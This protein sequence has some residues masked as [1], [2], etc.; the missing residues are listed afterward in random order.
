M[1]FQF[2]FAGMEIHFILTTRLPT[3]SVLN[4]FQIQVL[5][6]KNTYRINLGLYTVCDHKY[7]TIL[8]F[9]GLITST[10]NN[11]KA[12]IS[13]QRF[14]QNLFYQVQLLYYLRLNINVI[15]N[16]NFF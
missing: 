12:I 14:V 6:S 3:L 1:F 8:T 15:H 13:V 16:N 10:C 11:G 2:W 9:D 7:S 5:R 4:F